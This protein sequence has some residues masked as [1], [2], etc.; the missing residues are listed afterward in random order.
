MSGF[1]GK[2]A[3][4]GLMGLMGHIYPWIQGPNV[5]FYRLFCTCIVSALKIKKKDREHFFVAAPPGIFFISRVMLHIFRWK[6]THTPLM[7]S[8]VA[9]GF[10]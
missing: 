4:C 1:W 8:V 7:D 5:W 6:H 3:S 2:E 10:M 9:A